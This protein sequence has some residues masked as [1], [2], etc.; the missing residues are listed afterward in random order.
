VKPASNV[1][2]ESAGM[3]VTGRCSYVGDTQ[4]EVVGTEV[5]EAVSVL[6][7]MSLCV[8][9]KEEVGVVSAGRHAGLC[10]AAH[11]EP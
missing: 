5:A 6:E 2:A 8:G 3:C 9:K 7:H 11:H 4:L 10:E 1:S